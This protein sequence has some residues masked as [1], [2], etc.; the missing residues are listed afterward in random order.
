MK[1]IWELIK[2]TFPE[3]RKVLASDLNGVE[4]RPMI[5][6]TKPSF[7]LAMIFCWFVFTR[8]FI[9]LA[10]DPGSFIHLQLA[11]DSEIMLGTSEESG[12][13]FD[14]CIKDVRLNGETLPY[15]NESNNVALVKKYK[16]N[17]VK[18]FP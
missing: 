12:N 17:L 13:G 1:Y 14:G 16:G 5:K 7:A 15:F 10:Q 8:N 2:I 4:L 11:P 18:C 9:I 3:Q 6:S